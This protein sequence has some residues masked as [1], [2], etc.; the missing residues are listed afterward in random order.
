MKIFGKYLDERLF[1]K[2][3]WSFEKQCWDTWQRDDS[4]GFKFYF[5]I[6]KVWTFR[7]A[8]YRVEV[9]DM[10]TY[11]KNLFKAI[12]RAMLHIHDDGARYYRLVETLQNNGMWR[13]L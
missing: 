7:G 4:D 13:K 9:P 10:Y 11:D 8:T 2:K 3:L 6:Y 12:E 1:E 5:R